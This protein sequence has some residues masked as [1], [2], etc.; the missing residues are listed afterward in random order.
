MEGTPLYCYAGH[1]VCDLLQE[2]FT[3]AFHTAE[4]L[5]I[6]GLDKSEAVQQKRLLYMTLLRINY[7][8]IGIICAH[9]SP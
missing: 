9:Q 3:G 5:V 8:E 6:P 1:P 7:T 4:S 2:D